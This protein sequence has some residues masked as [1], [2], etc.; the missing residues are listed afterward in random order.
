VVSEGDEIWFSGS[1]ASSDPALFAVS[2][3]GRERLI[4][5]IAG[6]IVLQDVARDGRVLLNN[7]NSR[8]GI[9][10]VPPDGPANRDLR[11]S[12][13]PT[14]I[15]FPMTRGRFSSW[16][17]PTERAATP[18]STCARPMAHPQCAWATATA[19]RS[20][21]MASQWC[22]SGRSPEARIWWYFHGSGRLAVLDF[23]NMH[24]E[25]VE[26]FPDGRHLLFAANQPGRPIRSWTFDLESG[27]NQP[28]P[29]TAEGTRATA[30]SPNQHEVVRIEG[31]HLS[32]G[33]AL[34]APDGLQPRR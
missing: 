34:D 26:W 10:F 31:R 19:P 6:W 24:Y 15:P 16:N 9:L 14:L 2:L 13:H 22:A 4:F 8:L 21:T 17:W 7:V 1:H 12:T 23:G 5:Q 32:L 25:S 3:S 11:G 27:G 30:V 29:I 28:T 33:A 18:R 20:R